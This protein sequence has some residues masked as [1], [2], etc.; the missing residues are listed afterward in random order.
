MKA[1]WNNQEVHVHKYSEFNK[2]YLISK[3]NNADKKKFSV[4]AEQVRSVKIEK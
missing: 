4:P 2:Y 3:I 1:V